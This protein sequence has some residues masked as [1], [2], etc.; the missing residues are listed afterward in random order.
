MQLNA[1]KRLRRL[2]MAFDLKDKPPVDP[3]VMFRELDAGLTKLCGP[4]KTQPFVPKP[5]KYTTV[6][7]AGTPGKGKAIYKF[8]ENMGFTGVYKSVTHYFGGVRH[9][10][11]GKVTIVNYCNVSGVVS[12]STQLRGL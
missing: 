1:L 9:E 10:V 5:G 8:L 4:F 6:V 7:H 12:I 3:V 2:E 11:D